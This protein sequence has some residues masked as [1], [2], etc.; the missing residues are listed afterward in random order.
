MHCETK[1]TLGLLC[2]AK[3]PS[4]GTSVHSQWKAWPCRKL[5][6]KSH[7][8]PNNAVKRRRRKKIKYRLKK[9]QNTATVQPEWRRAPTIFVSNVPKTRASQKSTVNTNGDAILLL[10]VVPLWREKKKSDRTEEREI[11]KEHNEGKKIRCSFPH[12]GHRLKPAERTKKARRPEKFSRHFNK[13]SLTMT[14]LFGGG[15]AFLFLNA[16]WTKWHLHSTATTAWTLKLCESNESRTRKVVC[17]E[18]ASRL[19][20]RCRV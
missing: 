17:V 5:K 3:G 8:E 15:K 19:C 2:A 18:M 12:N 16:R 14:V 13:P 20:C 4:N 11:E 7:N 10:S 9:R 1:T 6:Y